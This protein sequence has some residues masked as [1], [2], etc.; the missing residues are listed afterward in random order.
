MI[1]LSIR[2]ITATIAAVLAVLCA[3]AAAPA[4]ST[5]ELSGSIYDQ[6]GA[7][8]P[9]V[10]MTIRGATDREGQTSTQGDFAF[11]ALPEGDYEISAELS[12]F[13]RARRVGARGGGRTSHRVPH[14]AGRHC[15]RNLR[16]GREGGRARRSDDSHGDQCD[17]RLRARAPGHADTVPGRCA[18]T[19]RH[20]LSER[21][22]QPA[23]N[24]RNRGERRERRIGS[25]LGDVPRRRLPGSTGDGVRC[26]SSISIASKCCADRRAHCTDATRLAAR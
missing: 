23:H 19:L 9:G 4:Q 24:P 6:T 20:A 8:L 13:E 14:V 11:Q 26:S 22:F 21:R 5:G 16:H 2:R 12:G 1:P 25:K 3:P 15:G 18:R 7:P 17:L 10:R